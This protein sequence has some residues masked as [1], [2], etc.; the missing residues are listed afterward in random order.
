MPRKR[1]GKSRS[2]TAVGF[3][4]SKFDA[5]NLAAFHH[6]VSLIHLECISIYAGDDK[7]RSKTRALR[8]DLG[9]FLLEIR[10]KYRDLNYGP[11][12]GRGDRCC[13]PYV[14]C[15]DHCELPELCSR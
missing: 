13:D 8:K 3:V 11:S 15:G 5:M 2:A 4:P 10:Q 1:P 14:D 7:D 12:A 6:Y 9:R